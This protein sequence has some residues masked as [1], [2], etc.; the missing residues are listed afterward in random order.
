MRNASAIEVSTEGLLPF[1]R[2]ILGEEECDAVV[3]A[4]RSGDLATGRIVAEF[5]EVFARRFGFAHAVAV[6]SGSA[7]NLVALAALGAL[8]RLERGTPIVVSGATFISAVSP[9]IQLGFVPVFVDV[10]AGE[11]NTDLALALA[12]VRK[13]GA[14][15]AL[16]PHTMGQALS[17]DG[18]RALRDEGVTVIEDCCESLGSADGDDRIGHVGD[19]ATFS[20]Y[21]GHH[22]TMGEG[23]V[24]GT[25]DAEL[26]AKL[27]S[28][29]AFG[30]DATYAGE[31][32]GYPVGDRR[33]AAEERYVHLHLGYN[34]KLT[35]IQAAI[36]LVQL[37]RADRL[38]EERRTLAGLLS[39]V[40]R[41]SGWRVLGDPVHR[42][43]SPFGIACLVPEGRSARE[44][45]RAL[46]AHGVDGRGFLGASLT[47]QPCFDDVPHVIHEPYRHVFELAD[48][49]VLIGCPPGTDRAAAV[50]ALRGAVEDLR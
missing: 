7:A 41:E 42:G 24:I 11:V 35:D 45:I 13:N 3:A 37:R 44:A 1:G 25:N 5:E 9:V 14:R 48:R 36:G 21:A 47:E 4:L 6:S 2:P 32:F 18:L 20:F 8:G 39:A 31:R 50:G 27:R 22:L 26:D 16:L 49:G 34:A 29:R 38:Q 23:G 10:K 33:I 19:A 46:C 30:R 17:T 15:G 43:S 28:I 12:A 40:L